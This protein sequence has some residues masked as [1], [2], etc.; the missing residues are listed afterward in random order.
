MMENWSFFLSGEPLNL[1]F[2]K[3][4]PALRTI[5]PEKIASLTH[6]HKLLVD[7]VLDFSPFSLKVRKESAFVGGICETVCL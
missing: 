7:V 2:D 3:A 4:H 5:V 6:L 1:F